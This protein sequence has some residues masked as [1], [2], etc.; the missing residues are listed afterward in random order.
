M[1]ESPQR[2]NDES[3]ETPGGT[4]SFSAGCVGLASESLTYCRRGKK[5]AVEVCDK[6]CLSCLKYLPL[7]AE[8]NG[9]P[10]ATCCKAKQ[11]S[12]YVPSLW[13]HWQWGTLMLYYQDVCF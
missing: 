5:P 13:S 4:A 9:F 3:Q 1:G 7:R 6:L 11:A 2:R 10:T 12:S 8:T